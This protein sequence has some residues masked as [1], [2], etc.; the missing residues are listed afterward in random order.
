LAERTVSGSIEEVDEPPMIVVTRIPTHRND[1]SEIS[2]GE[3][4]RILNRVLKK[5]RGFSF[6]GPSYGAGVAADGK[7][8]E[9]Q[10]YRLEVIV[11][12]ENVKAVQMHFMRI[13]KQLGQRAI[14]LEVREGGQ[15]IDLE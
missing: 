13:G 15:I 14:Y 9:E 5:F 4:T 11:P 8:Y 6:E 1:G 3:M 2:E 7:V 10:S 12:P